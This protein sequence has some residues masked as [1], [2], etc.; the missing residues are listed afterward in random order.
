MPN[1]FLSLHVDTA[2][3]LLLFAKGRLRRAIALAILAATALATLA[4]GEHYVIDLIPGV[5]FGCFAANAGLRR[6]RSA[7]FFLGAGLCWSFYVRFGS[8]ILIANPAVGKT[9]AGLT[10]G[11]AAWE[12]IREWMLSEAQSASQKVTELV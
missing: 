6:M 2:F 8:G 5:A 4:T 12:G 7:L 3:V 9:L 10:I 11:L 1:A